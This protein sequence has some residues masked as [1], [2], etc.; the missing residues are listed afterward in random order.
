MDLTAV[1]DKAK[2]QPKTK[3]KPNI[4]VLD[5]PENIRKEA[6]NFRAIADEITNLDSMAELARATIKQWTEAERERICSRMGFISSLKIPD[7]NNLL[8]T[9]SWKDQYSKITPES[10][11]SIRQIMG[12]DKFPIYMKPILS[13]K[14]RESAGNEGITKIIKALGLLA[15]TQ[16]GISAITS[17]GYTDEQMMEAGAEEFATYYEVEQGIKP[18]TRYTEEYFAV[19][20]PEQREALKPMV[21]QYEPTFKTK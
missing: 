10:I 17:S 16:S 1:L 8:L 4:P 18:S 3:G 11:A 5:A 20:T 14:V 13:I 21:K 19:F 15:L 12:E 7:T 9:L 2:A 6:S